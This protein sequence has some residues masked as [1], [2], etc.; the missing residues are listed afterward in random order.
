ME[1]ATCENLVIRPATAADAEEATAYVIRLTSEPNNNIVR[2][3]GQWE[4]TVEQEREFLAKAA[5]NPDQLFLV[6]VLEGRI[7]GSANILRRAPLTARHAATVGLSVDAA[8]RRRGIG[9]ALMTT[10]LEWARKQGLRRVELGV[11]T[12]NTVA[13]GLYLQMG[14]VVEGLHR[15]AYLKQGVWVDEYT[16]AL[17]L[18][19]VGSI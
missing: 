18:E 2:D 7:V 8:W 5:D 12:R 10:L 9:R 3:P 15:R 19:P 17:L 4:M 1:R 13:M 14:F 16:M 6:A 11:F